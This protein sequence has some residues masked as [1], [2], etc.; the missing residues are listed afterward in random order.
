MSFHIFYKVNKKIIK[1]KQVLKKF[2]F[3]NNSNKKH[4]NLK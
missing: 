2:V 4:F 1:N 3:S